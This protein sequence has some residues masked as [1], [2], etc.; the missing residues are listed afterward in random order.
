MNDDQSLFAVIL[1]L[2][3]VAFLYG[4]IGLLIGY[5]IWGP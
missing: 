3:I 1:F 4:G 2:I 5:R